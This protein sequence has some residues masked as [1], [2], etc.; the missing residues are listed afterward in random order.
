[1]QE[2]IDKKKRKHKLHLRVPVDHEDEKI[3]KSRANDCG[4]SIS[5]YLR[6]LGINY[7]PASIIDN[8]KVNEMAKI[9]GDLGRLGGLLKLWLSD[10]RRVAN[11]DKRAI[12]KLLNDIELTRSKM[13]GTMMQ[14][15][16]SKK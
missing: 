12:N 8:E 10:D 5:E 2:N 16:K 14:V 6:K 15:I 7:E 9:N 1:M 11:F 4:L 13:A 3:I